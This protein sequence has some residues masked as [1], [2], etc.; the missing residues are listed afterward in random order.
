MINNKKFRILF[1]FLVITFLL[2]SNS[3]SQPNKSLDA[4]QLKLAIKKLTVLGSVLYIAAHP[5][6]ENTAFLAYS[7]KGKLLETGYLSITRGD[8]G[9]NL[10]GT[11]Q[12]ELLGI[13]RTQELLQ[14]RRL[15]GAKQF[16]TRA[17]D[18]GYSKTII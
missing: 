5:D 1:T 18:F 11:E 13:I 14:A 7:S 10:I 9:Q 16:F 4:S 15:D 8:G 17:V 12:S 6:D 2:I 3:F